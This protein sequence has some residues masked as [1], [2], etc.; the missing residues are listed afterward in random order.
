PRVRAP[1]PSAHWRTLRHGRVDRSAQR[2]MT[3]PRRRSSPGGGRSRY[4]SR[5]SWRYSSL[6]WLGLPRGTLNR[7]HDAF[8][9][10]ATAEIRAHMRD[11]LRACRLGI[12][13]EQVGRAHDLSRLAIA[14]LRHLLGEPGLLQRVRRIRR[15]SFDRGHGL[16]CDL[17]D[18][19]LARKRALAVDMHHAGAA[20]TG[21]ATELSPGE[22]QRFPDHPQ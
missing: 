9:G 22:L 15:Q 7:A 6:S 12:L 20:Q 13:L 19:G 5:T 16:A 2:Q 21:P 3:I 17:R 8:I 4:Y 10:S 18:L 1:C 14:T 11:D